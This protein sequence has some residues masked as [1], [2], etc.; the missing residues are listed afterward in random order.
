MLGALVATY[1]SNQW[2]R[3]LLSSTVDAHRAPSSMRAPPVVIALLWVAPLRAFQLPFTATFGTP[4]KG[5]GLVLQSSDRQGSVQL[6]LGGGALVD[7][8]GGD[9]AR[10]QKC[11]RIVG[12]VARGAVAD[13][14]LAAFE[15]ACPRAVVP[16]RALSRA[17]VAEAA[18]LCERL[19]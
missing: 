8:D 12:V 19:T 13:R 2:C 3:A 6:W 7:A 18:R 16:F 4:G 10:V 5:E 1:A 15:A 14:D 11:C 9:G 17:S